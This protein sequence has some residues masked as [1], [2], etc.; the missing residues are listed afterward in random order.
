MKRAGLRT[1][2]TKF[3]CLYTDDDLLIGEIESAGI[4]AVI[5]MF[6]HAK[7]LLA[8]LESS[9]RK[10]PGYAD[11][12]AC[13]RAAVAVYLDNRHLLKLLEVPDNMQTFEYKHKE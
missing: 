3:N 12:A 13:R 4:A 7:A 11:T 8:E 6:G 2:V 9:G 5:K 1:G 10:N